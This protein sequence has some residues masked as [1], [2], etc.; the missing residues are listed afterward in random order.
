MSI[1][2][3]IQELAKAVYEASGGHGLF[4]IKLSPAGMEALKREIGA[5][6]RVEYVGSRLDWSVVEIETDGGPVRVIGRAI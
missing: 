3:A 5:G 1:T 4:E 6:L 2:V